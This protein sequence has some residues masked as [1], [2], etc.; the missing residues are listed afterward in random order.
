MRADSVCEISPLKRYNSSQS[1]S[2]G[3]CSHYSAYELSLNILQQYQ[4]TLHFGVFKTHFRLIKQTFHCFF[5][6]GNIGCF[7]YL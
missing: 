7:I 6:I 1:V 3:T 4:T 5:Q 2:S